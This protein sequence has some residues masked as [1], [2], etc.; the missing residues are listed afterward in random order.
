MYSGCEIVFDSSEVPA[1]A[2][3]AADH[4]E[5]VQVR[6][7]HAY[8]IHMSAVMTEQNP[9]QPFSMK[10]FHALHLCYVGALYWTSL[11]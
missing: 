7:D 10:L 5:D 3:A 6:P 8:D 1:R 11:A 9:P 2:V 4:V